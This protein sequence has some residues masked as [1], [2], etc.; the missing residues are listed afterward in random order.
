MNLELL[1][2]RDELEYRKKF[3]NLYC[4]GP[5]CTHDGIMV[6][7]RRE[8]FDHC[9]FE[10]VNKKKTKTFSMN[11]AQRL[12]WIKIA[13]ESETAKR[14]KGY[15]SKKKKVDPYRL[16]LLL[17]REHYAVI[18][19]LKPNRKAVFITAY[20]TTTKTEEK[21]MNRPW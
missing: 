4:S 17:G 5:L 6:R 1:D 16:V 10:T 14:Y 8:D 12:H 19:T 21:I 15:N 9:C 20:P 2:L 3:E 11:R 13:I 18:L 7:F